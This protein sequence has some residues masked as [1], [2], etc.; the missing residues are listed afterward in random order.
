MLQFCPTNASEKDLMERFAKLNIGAG[1]TFDLARLSP[2]SQKAVED[3]LRMSGQM[4]R[5]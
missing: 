5:R 4:L 2:E 1:K 3:G